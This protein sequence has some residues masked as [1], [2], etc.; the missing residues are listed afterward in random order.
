MSERLAPEGRILVGGE[1]VEGSGAEI[2][3]TDPADGTTV[4]TLAGAVPADVDRAVRRGEAARSA[5]AWRTML[6]HQRARYLARTAEL[7][8]DR[9]EELALLQSRDNGKPLAE[10][11]A[12][13]AS[14]AGT[15]RYVAALL[16]T[17]EGS[18]PPSRGDY[19]S[20]SVHEP[21]GVVGAI[22]PWNSPIASDAQ[23]VAPAL[24]AGNA[25]VLKP[26]AWTPLL[27]L[28]LG[29]LLL[30]AGIPEGLV[31]VLP[32]PGRTV[33]QAIV[34]HPGIGHLSFTGGTDTGR[35]LA[36]TAARLL[37]TTSLELGGKSPTIVLPDADLD[38]AV[39][40][41]LYGIFSSQ[42]QSCIAGSRLF[43]HDSVYDEVVAR[44]AERADALRVGHPRAEGTQLGPLITA[45]HRDA[46]ERFIADGLAAGGTLRAGGARPTD[47]ALAAGSYLRPTVIDG[48]RADASIVREEIFGPV[49]VA[50][51]WRDEEELVEAANDTSYGLACGIW[52]RDF[53][54]A[55]RIARAI[56]AGTVWVNTY[57]QLSIA[58][59]FGGMKDSGST[60]EKGLGAIR[61]Y[62]RQKSIYL[63]TSGPIAWAD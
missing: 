8:E 41:I 34:E 49:L 28:E 37:K 32:G 27:A 35:E 17:Q 45:S 47:P 54:R 13:V 51:R 39:N 50:L 16:E 61:A 10:T 7:I 60:R 6:P 14:A 2:V 22:T 19:L 1:W 4:A 44:V 12:L 48:L 3:A 40:G 42:G 62:Q 9:S 36:A 59:P 63:G 24:A 15:F 11:R 29:A 55:W 20:F 33:G 58:T 43:V 5:A 57:K 38:V 18:I 31:S 53:A 46:V 52:T 56:D 30:E 21:I 23:K 26:A 25:V